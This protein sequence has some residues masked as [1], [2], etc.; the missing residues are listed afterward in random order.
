MALHEITTIFPPN[1]FIITLSFHGT[2]VVVFDL[3]DMKY[4]FAA[5][6]KKFNILIPI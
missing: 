4:S 5:Y 1:A 3:F 6:Q 2:E